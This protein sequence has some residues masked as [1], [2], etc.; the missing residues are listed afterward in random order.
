MTFQDTPREAPRD[1]KRPDSAK[2]LGV[3]GA[4]GAAVAK[5][6]LEAVA[7]LAWAGGAILALHLWGHAIPLA[8]DAVLIGRNCQGEAVR[9]YGAD[10]G[11]EAAKACLSV[12]RHAMPGAR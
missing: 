12:E 5:G 4:L 9:L 11:R 6:F 8:P 2:P 3:A 10:D 1:A 7:G